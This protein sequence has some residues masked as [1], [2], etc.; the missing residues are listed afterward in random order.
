[1]EIPLTQG[2]VALI[3]DE[4]W[5][6]V[7]G[8][9]WYAHRNRRTMYVEHCD[10]RFNVKLHR[11]IT[12]A[13]PGVEVD[14]RNGDGLDNRRSNLRVATRS[15]NRCNGIT[16]MNKSG[17]KGVTVRSSGRC[18]AVVTVQGRRLFLGSFSTPEDAARAYDAAARELHGEFARL[19]FP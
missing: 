12:S 13:A 4:D 16:R 2:K 11:L 1:M 6:L 10:G 7:A 17:Y 5:P 8:F 18:H 15:Q 14:H 3:D 19:N 9:K